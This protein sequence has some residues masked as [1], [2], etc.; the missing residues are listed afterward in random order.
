MN[1][2]IDKWP[3]TRVSWR[4]LL[5]APRQWIWIPF[6]RGSVWITVFFRCDWGG[7]YWRHNQND[8]EQLLAAPMDSLLTQ[9]PEPLLPIPEATET[10]RQVTR[11]CHLYLESR[12]SHQLHLEG[13]IFIIFSYW[14]YTLM[15][16]KF[17]TKKDYYWCISFSDGEQSLQTF[18]WFSHVAVLA[19]QSA[20]DTS[21]RFIPLASSWYASAIKVLPTPGK[22]KWNGT[23]KDN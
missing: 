4:Q 12:I 1:L 7:E 17:R 20:G 16:I 11:C 6:L 2:K 23:I 9:A 14:L 10:D 22:L 8:D 5:L 21:I 13:R 15:L 19:V 18:F 3:L